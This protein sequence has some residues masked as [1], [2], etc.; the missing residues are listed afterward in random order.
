[1]AN[2]ELKQSVYDAIKVSCRNIFD[3]KKI[4]TV[5]EGFD[6]LMRLEEIPMHCPYHHF[7]L[8]AVMLTLAAI[9]EEKSKDELEAWLET[10]EERGKTVPGGFC[11]NCGTC[12]SAVGMGIFAAVYTGAS[13]MTTDSWQVANE[14]T[15]RS[16]IKI[17]EYPGPRCCK[18]TAYLAAIAAVPFINEK[19]GT[20]FSIDDK[21]KC[22]FSRFNAE[23]LRGECPFFREKGNDK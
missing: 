15:G 19:L 8:P 13:P 18:R 17:A 20:G 11:G 22:E 21:I 7:I 10:A 12:G 9:H 4:V 1:M 2:I 6:A 16:L 23:C 14:T 5:N 3:A